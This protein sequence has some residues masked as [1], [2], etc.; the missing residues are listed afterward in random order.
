MELHKKHRERHRRK[1]QAEPRPNERHS[2]HSREHTAVADVAPVTA[3][4]VGV[5]EE[6]ETSGEANSHKS[7]SV[8]G[9]SRV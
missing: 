4:L 3:L 1:R 8:S 6:I 7:S 2:A 5:A 9:V